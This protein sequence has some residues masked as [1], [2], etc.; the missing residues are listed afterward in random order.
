MFKWFACTVFILLT[1]P[2]VIHAQSNYATLRGSV[3]DKDQHAIPQ[4]HIRLTAAAT[5]AVRDLSAD[6]AGLYV[7]EGLQPGAYHV[8]ISSADFASSNE[9]I[10]LEV[11]QQ[12]TLDE[13]L[14]VSKQTETVVVKYTPELLKTADASIGEVVDQQSVDQLPL[15][16]RQLINLV[17]TV[18]GAH[19][20][21]GAQAGN[22]NPLYWRPGQFSA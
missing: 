6:A 20:S 18:P 14:A 3:T 2:A 21:M 9:S 7:A 19:Q 17:M 13:R 1:L 10:Q 16:G 5:G 11:G 22:A 4:A 12:M 15:N 8:E